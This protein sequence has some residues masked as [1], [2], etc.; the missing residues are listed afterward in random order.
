MTIAIAIGW[1]RLFPALGR[2][3]RM[4]DIEPVEVGT[5]LAV[6]SA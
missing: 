5:D 1:I 4:N 2:V 6:D 3:D